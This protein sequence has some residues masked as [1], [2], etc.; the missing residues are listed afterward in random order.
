VA[1]SSAV[2]L[3]FSYMNIFVII[4]FYQFFPKFVVAVGANERE[5]CKSAKKIKLKENGKKIVY[6]S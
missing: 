4:V 5:A 1:E 3:L 6:T 2:S